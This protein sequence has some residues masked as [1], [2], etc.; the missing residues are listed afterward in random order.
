MELIAYD[1][2]KIE[3]IGSYKKTEN[4]RIIDEFIESGLDC[5]KVEGFTQKRAWSCAD[6]L[7]K[8]MVRMKKA[9]IKALSRKG[10]VYLVKLETK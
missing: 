8:T 2:D 1:R 7:N 10:E 9:G 4:M 5:A 3:N 6:S